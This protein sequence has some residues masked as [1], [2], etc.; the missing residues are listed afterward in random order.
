MQPELISKQRCF[1]HSQREAVVR[2]P[3]CGRYYCR[4]CVTEHLDRLLCA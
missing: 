3:E 4:E 1:F 2:C